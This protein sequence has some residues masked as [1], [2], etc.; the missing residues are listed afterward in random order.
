[1]T[2]FDWLLELVLVGLLALVL[3]HAI[4]LERAVTALRRDRVALGDAV[5]GFDT[6]TRA[7]QAGLG[8]LRQL[9]A[10]A[11]DDIAHRVAA[12]K[13]LRDDLVYLT[14]RGGQVADRLEGLVRMG[15]TAVAASAPPTAVEPQSGRTEVVKPDTP[16]PAF[17]GRPADTDALMAG[18]MQSVRPNG[19]Q[20]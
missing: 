18:M 1:M 12:G 17:R 14:E 19:A 3:W 7:A 4:R 15:R 13:A 5:A 8:Q 6:S 2:G 10:T 16:R 11:A 9:T 20:T